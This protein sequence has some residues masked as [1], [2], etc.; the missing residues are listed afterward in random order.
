MKMGVGG[1]RKA[2]ERCAYPH[3]SLAA[4]Y[5]FEIIRVVISSISYRNVEIHFLFAIRN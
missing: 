1:G 2:R 3:L 4:V 5:L